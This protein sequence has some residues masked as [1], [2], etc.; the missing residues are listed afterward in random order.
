VQDKN[1]IQQERAIA[2]K[3]TTAVKQELQK[4]YPAFSKRKTTVQPRTPAAYLTGVRY[5]MLQGFLDRIT[6]EAPKYSFHA[7]YGY[8]LTNT[9]EEW[10]HRRKKHINIQQSP[11][12]REQPGIL[13]FTSLNNSPALNQ[14]ATE[15][16]QIRF[17]QVGA[18]LL[19]I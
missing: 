4:F 10:K 6:I 7:H 5:K 12:D 1:L 17:M 2:S 14:L 16:S 11:Q 8:N 15:V 18:M 19:N 3:A 13:Q 9:V